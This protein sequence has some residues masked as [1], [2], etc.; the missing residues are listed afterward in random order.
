MDREEASNG[1]ESS[2]VKEDGVIEVT[3]DIHVHLRDVTAARRRAELR[4]DLLDLG[5]VDQE[6]GAEAVHRKVAGVAPY[7]GDESP[8]AHPRGANAYPDRA[9][10]RNNDRALDD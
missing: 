2:S 9:V 4:K 1:S 8:L 5:L 3:V 10:L 7:C 6:L